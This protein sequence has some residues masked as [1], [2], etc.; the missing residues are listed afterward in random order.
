MIPSLLDG[1]EFTA[2]IRA[3][4][5]LAWTFVQQMM[6]EVHDRVHLLGAQ[7][8]VS[9]AFPAVVQNQ[10]GLHLLD[11][12]GGGEWLHGEFFACIVAAAVGV[13]APALFFGRISCSDLD[14][15]RF[16]DDAGAVSALLQLERDAVAALALEAVQHDDD[17][18]VD[19]VVD[20][21]ARGKVTLIA[22]L[23]LLLDLS[24]GYLEINAS[25]ERQCITVWI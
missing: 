24:L 16:A 13:R 18:W 15:T 11:D 19:V 22:L 6:E 10:I 5:F 2:A 14:V 8:L 20:V 25:L 9:Q 23:H 21:L 3:D 4:I 7:F 12:D 17:G 1:A